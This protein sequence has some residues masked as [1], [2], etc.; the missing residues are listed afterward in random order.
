MTD[1][2]ALARMVAMHCEVKKHGY[3]QTQDGVVVSFVLHPE[4]IPDNLA[5]APLGTRYT[6][7][8]VEL[9]DDDT[10]KVEK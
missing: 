8:L 6:L 5:T 1:N 7:A 4:E 9:N 3:R 10:P 2:A